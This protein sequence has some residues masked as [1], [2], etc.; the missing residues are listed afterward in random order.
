MRTRTLGRGRRGFVARELAAFVAWCI[1]SRAPRY[2]FAQDDTSVVIERAIDSSRLLEA[3]GAMNKLLEVLRSSY[4][5][6]GDSVCDAFESTKREVWSTFASSAICGFGTDG[7]A[8]WT[9]ISTT[10]TQGAFAILLNKCSSPWFGD[11]EN[12]VLTLS[13][14]FLA[15]ASLQRDDVS[16]VIAAND[17]KAGR[18]ATQTSDDLN[19][20]HPAFYDALAPVA[21]ELS[22]FSTSRPVIVTAAPAS[23]EDTYSSTYSAEVSAAISAARARGSF[24]TAGDTE[25]FPEDF[26]KR[27]EN[28]TVAVNLYREKYLA[29]PYSKAHYDKS[30]KC[31]GRALTD[32]LCFERKIPEVDYTHA[33]DGTRLLTFYGEGLSADFVDYNQP[34]QYVPNVRLD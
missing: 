26:A 20:R 22:S 8:T 28:E 3:V 4:C 32:T 24:A 2:I 6:D 10:N 23:D 27:V 17:A 13:A 14:T 31:A 1:V 30:T 12:Q 9:S 29:H 21:T 34:I 16:A 33:A 25:A 15:Q 5:T 7:D 18:A 19:S 11:L